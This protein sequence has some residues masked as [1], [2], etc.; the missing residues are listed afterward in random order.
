M[1]WVHDNSTTIFVVCGLIFC[2]MSFVEV[3]YRLR[4]WFFSFIEIE[5]TFLLCKKNVLLKRKTLESYTT[6]QIYENQLHRHARHQD[7]HKND[8]KYN[9]ECTNI[10]RNCFCFLS[11]VIYQKYKNHYLNL[12]RPKHNHNNELVML[13]FVFSSVNKYIWLCGTHKL[14]RFMLF[15]I[16]ATH[17]LSRIKRNRFHC[18]VN[19]T[20]YNNK[21]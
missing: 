6:F 21:K 7:K 1:F 9:I 2:K 15:P 20:H 10:I 14:L 16:T 11:F 13:L 8:I 5:F 18:N 17:F 19:Y 3:P 4:F 12:K